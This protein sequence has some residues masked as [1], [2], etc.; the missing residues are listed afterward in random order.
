M[1]EEYF[2]LSTVTGKSYDVFKTVKILNIQQV[3]YYLSKN[4]ELRDIR[5]SLDKNGKAVLVFYFYKDDTKEAYDEWCKNK[6]EK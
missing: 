5:Q 6:E 3:C 4:V 1:S 2:R